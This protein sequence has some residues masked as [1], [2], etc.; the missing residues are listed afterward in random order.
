MTLTLFLFLIPVESRD[1]LPNKAYVVI[2]F[3]TL[4]ARR[5]ILLKWK[6]Q[7]PPSFTQWI[8]DVL[9]FLKLEQIKCTLKASSQ[10]FVKIWRP[11][12]NYYDSLQEPLDVE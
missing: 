2:A 7:A 4:L 8:K 11:F 1:L 6:Q 9:Y 12:L 10:T 5:L 3:S